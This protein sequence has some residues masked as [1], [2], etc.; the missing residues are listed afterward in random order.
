[1]ASR[2]SYGFDEIPVLSPHKSEIHNDD[3]VEGNKHKIN[4]ML[5]LELVR[6]RIA[7][8]DKEIELENLLQK[9]TM[10]LIHNTPETPTNYKADSTAY[11]AGID[12]SSNLPNV[13]SR[14]LDLIKRE[15]IRFNGNPVQYWS[16][17]RNFEECIDNQNIG[18]KAKLNYLIE[19]IDGEAKS[20][21]RHCILLEPDVGYHKALELL[22]DM[23]GLKHVVAHIFTDKLLAIP[24]NRG[25]Y[26]KELRKLS[27]E[28]QVCDL[29]LKQMNYISDSNS[30]HLMKIDYLREL[31]FRTLFQ[32]L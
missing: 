7:R 15:I 13:I 3:R 22:E 12:L 32:I 19:Y 11:E 30:G 23:F 28:M 24:N 29:T 17:I 10:S 26:P 21:I 20:I 25:N 31:F 6:L 16:F 27:T 18:Y 14:N 5:E 8:L 9:T 4:L 2:K 1:M